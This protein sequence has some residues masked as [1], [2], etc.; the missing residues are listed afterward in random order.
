M[1]T[2]TDHTEI[3]DRLLC[4]AFLVKDG[5]I[6]CANQ[7]AI[8]R[9]INI[10]DP[11]KPLISSGEQ[12]YEGFTSGRLCLSLMIN[13]VIYLASVT[14]LE[15]NNLFCLESD[16]EDAEL[17]AFALVSQCLR[18]PLSEALTL[19][20]SIKQSNTEAN[21]EWEA[22]LQSINRNLHQF[23]RALCNM[24]DVSSF[25][26]ARTSRSEYRNIVSIID[27][28]MEK[29]SSL[30]SPNLH[31]LEYHGLQQEV[32]GIVDNEKLERA[33]LN[34]ISNAIKYS[35]KTSKI[36]V[37]LNQ[38]SGKLYFSVE[39]ELQN[40]GTTSIGNL[41]A[42]Y[43]REP[44]LDSMNTGVGLGLTMVRKA[45]IAH[46]GALLVDQ[47]D[48]NSIRFTMSVAVRSKAGDHMHS[49]V[50]LPIDYAGGFDHTLVELSDILAAEWFE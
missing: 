25:D 47:P 26:H 7:A 17:R 5:I 1:E 9:Q 16:Y 32:L 37:S 23:H 43:L 46:G 35:P 40:Q 48:I 27:A 33:I 6:S 20:N 31:T 50:M 2:K 11:L 24:S 15:D 41:F 28:I 34:L 36:I 39:N 29:A 45:A 13:N 42:R 38:T 8:T 18:E 49:P 10:G 30:I 21:P 3:L 22:K 44:G 4:P 12:E 14:K 19:V